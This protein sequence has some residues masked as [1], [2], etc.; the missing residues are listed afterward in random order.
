MNHTP[1][2]SYRFPSFPIDSPVI[3][4]ALG[5]LLRPS[6]ETQ[7]VPVVRPVAFIRKL[8]RIRTKIWRKSHRWENQIRG[9]EHVSG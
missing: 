9:R 4:V 2:I 7:R 1:M 6:A 8:R 5:K 3:P